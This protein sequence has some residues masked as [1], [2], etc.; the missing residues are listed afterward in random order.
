MDFLFPFHPRTVHFPIAL[1]LVGVFFVVV[2]AILTRRLNADAH[3]AS[4]WLRF[5]RLMLTIGWVAVLVA[6]ATGLVDQSRAGEDAEVV[7]TINLHI[8][9]GVALVVVLGIAL[10]WPLRDRQVLTRHRWAYVTLL[11]LVAALVLAESWLGGTLV[12]QLGVGVSAMP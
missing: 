2:S 3:A 6:I 5:G 9:M 4:Q 7:R 11:L 12:Y 1:T 8:T 10:Y